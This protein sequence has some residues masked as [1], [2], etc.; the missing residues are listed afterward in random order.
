[1][2]SELGNSENV[3]LLGVDV[4]KVRRTWQ[5]RSL[6][7]GAHRR[8][9]VALDRAFVFGSEAFNLIVVAWKFSASAAHIYRITASEFFLVRIF[10]VLP[11][12]HPCDSRIRNVIRCRRLTEQLRQATV[13][14]AA[15]KVFTEIT[16]QLPA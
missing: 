15:I 11:S 9:V 5:R 7:Q 12:R 8:R 6:N 2:K 16:A 4:H 3:F 1:M 13:A 14:R 10:Q